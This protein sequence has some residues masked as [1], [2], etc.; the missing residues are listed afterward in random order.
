MTP[1]TIEII[2]ATV[3]T[4]A[5]A[6]WLIAIVVRIHRNGG[7]QP[8]PGFGDLPPDDGGPLDGPDDYA[9][10]AMT[11]AA[12]TTYLH[13]EQPATEP[14]AEPEREGRH[15]APELPHSTPP[16]LATYAAWVAAGCPLP[17]SWRT[18]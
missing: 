10:A 11:P 14:A 2:A 18:A 6:G 13:V 9:L 4:A 7:E 5:C 16:W 17:H 3:G 8:H 15:R 12:P 1:E